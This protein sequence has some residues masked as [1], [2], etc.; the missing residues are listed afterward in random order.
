MTLLAT[1][2]NSKRII[3]FVLE[4]ASAGQMAQHVGYFGE[5]A[6]C[7]TWMQGWNVV[8]KYLRVPELM[9]G[10]DTET[11][12]L[13]VASER[14]ISYGFCAYHY[15]KPVW[16][17]QFFVIP[18]RPIAPGALKVHGLSIED[19]EAKRS[20]ETVL[21]VKG[22]LLRAVDILRRYQEREGSERS[23]G[24]SVAI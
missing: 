9:L 16:D 14:A 5:I 15:G 6:R 3:F 13:D 24:I 8:K 17:E 11:T 4:T 7:D 19:L 21:S 2:S 20:S 22:G 23:L 1:A 12:G 10:F 18:D